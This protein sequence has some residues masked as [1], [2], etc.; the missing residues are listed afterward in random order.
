MRDPAKARCL[1]IFSLTH[2]SP[3]LPSRAYLTSFFLPSSP[4]G[5]WGHWPADRLPAH[6]GFFPEGSQAPPDM[7]R[8][9][10]VP[11]VARLD[12]LCE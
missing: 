5:S 9:G 11:A 1:H 2:L 6:V 4:P 12:L 8:S 3:M 10:R 7:L